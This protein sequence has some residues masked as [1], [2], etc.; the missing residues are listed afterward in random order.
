MEQRQQA[1]LAPLGQQIMDHWKAH[2][3]SYHQKLKA[4]GTL[5]AAAIELQEAV[6]AEQEELEKEGMTPEAAWEVAS[7][8][9]FRPPSEK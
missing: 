4:A 9:A 5:E 7:Q 2:H 8:A 3:P 1:D 6:L